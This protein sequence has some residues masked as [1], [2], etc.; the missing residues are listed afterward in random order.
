MIFPGGR[1][2]LTK[3]HE[4]NNNVTYK[5]EIFSNKYTARQLSYFLDSGM[6]GRGRDVPI[7]NDL[8]NTLP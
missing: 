4:W 5:L 7:F 6:M 2:S 1:D 8:M 3:D